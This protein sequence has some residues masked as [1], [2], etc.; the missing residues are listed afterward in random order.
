MRLH[1]DKEHHKYLKQ[2]TNLNRRIKTTAYITTVP[3]AV[4]QTKVILIT[5]D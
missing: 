4:Y 2:P 5:A 3:M 1:F